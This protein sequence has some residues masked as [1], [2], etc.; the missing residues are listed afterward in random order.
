ML[1]AS[2]AR[3]A[4]SFCGSTLNSFALIIG[5]SRMDIASLGAAYPCRKTSVSG[6]LCLRSN[7]SVFGLM[8][9]NL[10]T[11][12]SLSKKLCQ[13]GLPKFKSCFWR[14]TKKQ[15]G[16]QKTL[17]ANEYKPLGI[18]ANAE[19]TSWCSTK[20]SLQY[21]GFWAMW[22]PEKNFYFFPFSCRAVHQDLAAASDRC[23][24]L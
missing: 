9:G 19:T 18:M 16:T 2:L 7:Q 21:W 10:P 15:C 23:S 5:V 12:C 3:T 4:R 22:E 8:P 20:R 11:I 14:Y 17:T 24:M 1:A 6:S 13:V